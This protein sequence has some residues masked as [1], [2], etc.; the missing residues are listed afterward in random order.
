MIEICHKKSTHSLPVD[1][2]L[3]TSCKCRLAWVAVCGEQSLE[4]ST[5]CGDLNNF[6]CLECDYL[7]VFLQLR[8]YSLMGS[9]LVDPFLDR[10]VDKKCMTTEPLFELQLSC[11]DRLMAKVC[12][13]Y[14]CLF[15][16]TMA[17]RRTNLV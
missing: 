16:V 6:G 8:F 9:E 7:L 17:S 14:K 13:N 12:L 11:M 5:L 1:S 4:A 3:L 15:S 2:K 10:Y